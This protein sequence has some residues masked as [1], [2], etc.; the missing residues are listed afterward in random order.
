MSPR[1][2]G[3]AAV[4]L[5]VL[6]AAS[7]LAT[8]SAHTHRGA[9][10]GGTLVVGLSAGD[11]GS[12]DPTVSGTSSAITIYGA[13]CERLYQYVRNHGRVGFA[14]LLAESLPVL[15][16]DKLHYTVQLRKGI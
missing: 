2:R 1:S 10:Y 9:K 16:K 15:S 4:G 3:T 13:I 11:P 14:P 7:L 6:L 8:A 12:L 5:C